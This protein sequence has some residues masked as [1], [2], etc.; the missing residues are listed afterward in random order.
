MSNAE[1]FAI[2]VI[3]ASQFAFVAF[4]VWCVCRYS[5]GKK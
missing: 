3:V 5:G 4:A 2:A 1:A